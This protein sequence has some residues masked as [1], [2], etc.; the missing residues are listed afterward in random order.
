M[1][2]ELEGLL[3]GSFFRK[4]KNK[5]SSRKCP[6]LEEQYVTRKQ[7]IRHKP[8]DWYHIKCTS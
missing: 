5:N 1:R 8:D 2:R 4:M 7:N 3:K 6:L